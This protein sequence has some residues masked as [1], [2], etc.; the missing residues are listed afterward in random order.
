[1]SAEMLAPDTKRRQLSDLI[2][3]VKTRTP[4]VPNYTL[5]LGAGASVTSNVR[6]ATD[7]VDEW[8][9]EMYARYCKD[10]VKMPY[11][12]ENARALFAQEHGQWY[13]PQREYA[14]LFEKKFDLPRQRRM[15]VEREVDGKQPSMGYAYLIRL[16]EENYFNTV[17]TTNFDDLLNEA[18]HQFS[19]DRPIVCAHDSSISSITVTSKRPKIIKLHGD[20][21][22]DDI[23]STVRETE[24]LE[25]NTKAK[26]TEFAKDHGLIVV[27][28]SGHDRSIMEVLHALLKRDDYLKHGL[29]WCRRASDPVSEDLAKLLWKDRAYWVE[30]EGFDE[31]VAQLHE[32]CIGAGLPIS[33]A[34]VSDHPKILISKFCESR[35][36]RESSS[37]IIQRDLAKL[38]D[39]LNNEALVESIRTLT[40]RDDDDQRPQYVLT[41]REFIKLMA[42]KQLVRDRQLDKAESQIASELSAT[43]D[44]EFRSSLYQV[45]LRIDDLRENIDGA[46]RTCEALIELDPKNASSYLERAQIE[47]TQERR[48]ASIAKA[49]ELDPFYPQAFRVRALMREE[50]LDVAPGAEYDNLISGIEADYE[51]SI[52]LDPSITNPGWGAWVDFLLQYKAPAKG[53]FQ[54]VE[55]ILA[56]M[57]CLDAYSPNYLRL[58]IKY[59]LR[60]DIE[61]KEKGETLEAI[62]QALDAQPHGRRRVIEMVMLTALRKFGKKTELLA[63][64]SEMELE[65]RAQK[66]AE[67]VDFRAKMHAEVEGKVHDAIRV[68]Q[69]FQ[70][71]RRNEMIAMRLVKYLCYVE[72]YEDAQSFLDDVGSAYSRKLCDEMRIGIETA[73]GNYDRALHL[74][75]RVKQDAIFPS[76]RTVE[77]TNLLLLLGR[78]SE[79]ESGARAVLESTNYSPNLAALIINLELARQRQG[80]KVDKPRLG[81]AVEANFGDDAVCLGAQFLMDDKEHAAERL[82]KLVELDRTDA[83]DIRGWSMFATPPARNWV[84]TVLSAKG[85]DISELQLNEPKLA[86]VGG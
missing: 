80:C 49:I 21:L 76:E 8:R 58:R 34:L 29:Y 4:N 31:L 68:L 71:I 64:L 9:R 35:Y 7:L 60:P 18:F 85:L 57:K 41:D 17:F 39:E 74:V 11:S 23:K 56:K 42:I 52:E 79:A 37:P 44:V 66:D 48:L 50:Q 22:F 6:S 78:H 81:K 32:D 75:R 28:Y 33:T 20:Y 25:E 63:R 67:L 40:R 46:I 59:S 70:G 3:F 15:F 55:E 77:E 27:G 43:T 84:K 62:Q 47:R 69:S 1:M 82:R 53:R 2:G 54:K 30:I 36:L 61:A 19:E 65:P 12:P 5:L 26:F 73:R 10:L 51:R 83:Y 45:R 72:R 14:S 86:S 13:S 24:S 38:K 16:I